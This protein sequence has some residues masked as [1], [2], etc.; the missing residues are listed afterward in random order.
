MPSHWRSRLPLWSSHGMPLACTLVPGAC[1]TISSFAVAAALTTGLGPKGRLSSQMRQAR[2][3]A[4]KLSNCSMVT[5]AGKRD[6]KDT[7]GEGKV[8][9]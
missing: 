2:T 7:A 8:E 3:F 4:N 1:P 6:G 9:S 5:N